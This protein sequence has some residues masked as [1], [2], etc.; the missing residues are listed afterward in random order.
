M[1]A[2]HF[3]GVIA[4]LAFASAA[5]AQ[6]SDDDRQRKKP[7][8]RA[9]TPYAPK[10]TTPAPTP[11]KPRTHPSNPNREYTREPYRPRTERDYEP[12]RANR[13]SKPPKT[14]SSSPSTP[15]AQPARSA[16]KPAETRDPALARCDKYRARMEQVIREEQRGGDP[17]RMPRLAEERK[18]VYQE[19]MR[20]GC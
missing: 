10:A 4:A 7:S 17:A 12:W 8:S 3:L 13:Q 18:Q 19:T 2:L 1:H 11:P 16:A 6:R 20:A 9:S 5:Y 14:T 15:K